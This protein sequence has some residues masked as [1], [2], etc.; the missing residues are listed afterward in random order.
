MHVVRSAVTRA[1]VREQAALDEDVALG[2][3]VR[4]YCPPLFFLSGI[5]VPKMPGPCDGLMPWA[6]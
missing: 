5:G 2:R 3:D 6:S 4:D 1:V